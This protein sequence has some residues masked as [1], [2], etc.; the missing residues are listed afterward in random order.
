MPSISGNFGGD[1]GITPQGQLSSYDICSL[2]VAGCINQ[3]LE[4][5]RNYIAKKGKHINV[6]L[7]ADKLYYDALKKA[8]CEQKR[9][10]CLAKEE[11]P[12]S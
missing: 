8:K 12:V 5:R 3:Q 2:Q 1:S 10:A 9:K 4:M 6:I 11:A 7:K